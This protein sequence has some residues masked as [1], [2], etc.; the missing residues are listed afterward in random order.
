MQDT[1][2]EVLLAMYDDA[3]KDSLDLIADAHPFSPFNHNAELDKLAEFRYKV[4]QELRRR[5]VFI[6]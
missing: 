1:S 2:T 5:G 6:P 4:W 3:R